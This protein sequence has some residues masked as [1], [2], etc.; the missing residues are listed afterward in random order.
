MTTEYLHQYI[1][2]FSVSSAH[3]Q[4][5]DVTA[6]QLRDA[7]RRRMRILLTMGD[8]E[9]LEVFAKPQHSPIIADPV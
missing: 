3:Y 1:A 7:M 6:A 9:L 8:E 2:T 5:E 4:G